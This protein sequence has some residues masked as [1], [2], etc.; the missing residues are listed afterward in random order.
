MIRLSKSVGCKLGLQMS[1]NFDSHTFQTCVDDPLT[2]TLVS[3]KAS[4]LKIS[5]ATS[6]DSNWIGWI[7]PLQRKSILGCMVIAF[8]IPSGTGEFNALLVKHF[9]PAY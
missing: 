5:V 3:F 1:D 2:T 8:C 9:L 6:I 4:A 7:L